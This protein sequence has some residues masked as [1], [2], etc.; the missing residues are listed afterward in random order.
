VDI[1]G[2]KNWISSKEDATEM[3]ANCTA[4]KAEGGGRQTTLPF[5]EPSKDERSSS[6][7]LVVLQI[8]PG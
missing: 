4:M 7:S 5:Q 2:A 3:S 6:S 1:R 8:S